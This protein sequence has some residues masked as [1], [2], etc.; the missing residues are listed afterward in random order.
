VVVGGDYF[1]QKDFDALS[2]DEKVGEIR[3]TSLGK[4]NNLINSSL[5]KE[6]DYDLPEFYTE[7]LAKIYTEQEY[8]KEAIDVY[9]KLIL[10]YPEKS[11][12]FASLVKEIKLKN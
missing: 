9:A 5:E 11:A 12:Y 2:D 3:V 10:L 8:Y 4:D 1:S 6:V 7:T